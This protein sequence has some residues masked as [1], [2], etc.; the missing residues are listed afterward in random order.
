M[1]FFTAQEIALIAAAFPA[2]DPPPL[3]RL[4][5]AIMNEAD[6]LSRQWLPVVPEAAGDANDMSWMLK[7]DEAAFVAQAKAAK[8]LGLAQGLARAAAT[9]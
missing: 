6:A 8:M 5:A 3:A 4:E 7:P 9:A 1:P 2:F